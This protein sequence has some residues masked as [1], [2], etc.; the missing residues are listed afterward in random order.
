MPA[1]PETYA[2]AS[3][4]PLGAGRF[5]APDWAPAAGEI[6]TISKPAG[7]F[8]TNGGALLEEIDPKYQA[9]NPLAPSQG[10]YKG[11]EYYW[12]SVMGYSGLAHN[13]D[14]RQLVFYGAGHS[15]INVCA[16]YC[17]DLNDLRWKWLDT[18]L[19]AD[20]YKAFSLSGLAVNKA[21]FDSIYP[22]EQH[23][24]DWGEWKG[25]WAGWETLY[26]SGPWLRPGKI[27]TSPGHSRGM[28]SHIPASIFGNSKGA[29]LMLQQPTGMLSGVGGKASHVFD[30]DLSSQRR[31]ANQ[32]QFN[33]LYNHQK[34][35]VIDRVSRK[36]VAFGSEDV[37]NKWY[38][39]DLLAETWVTRTAAANAYTT[40]DHGGNTL[41]E[42]SRLIIVPCR[43]AGATPV[44]VG[45]TFRFYAVSVDDVVGSGSFSPVVLDV[46]VDTDWPINHLGDN[47]YIGWEYCPADECL[48]C[49]NGSNGSTNYWRLSPPDG[50]TTSGQ[51]I[52]GTWTL[53]KHTFSVGSLVSTG[54]N[55][56]YVYNRLSWDRNSRSMIWI[57]DRIIDPVQAFRPEGI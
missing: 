50:A 40:G 37:H 4:E 2:I 9:W 29:M 38:V 45:T 31:L 48:Y 17:F 51:Y 34:G 35:I 5:I 49:I 52:S 20:G 57:S 42:A 18:P 53:T 43:M 21:N 24:Y 15:S 47:R 55:P 39:M 27:Q 12:T 23:D 44:S 56:S 10:P 16:P 1:S 6:K 46:A 11:T 41:H 22:P 14:A 3:G 32:R 7:F 28:L 19:P 26:G 25:D 36:A 30:Y 8:G 54:Q 33:S 13:T